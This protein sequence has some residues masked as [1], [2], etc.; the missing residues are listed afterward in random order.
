MHSAILLHYRTAYFLESCS[1]P[2]SQKWSSVPAHW[3]SVLSVQVSDLG[4]FTLCG[5][6][7]PYKFMRHT[8]W[9]VFFS[10]SGHFP[11]A[12][13]SI[14]TEQSKAMK[15]CQRRT[16]DSLVDI[17]IYFLLLSFYSGLCIR[18]NDVVSERRY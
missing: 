15:W 5:W 17:Y 9:K 11:A 6:T 10:V 4:V 1:W 12:S 13:L 18:T 7:R 16:A 2:F 14:A 8:F 3:L